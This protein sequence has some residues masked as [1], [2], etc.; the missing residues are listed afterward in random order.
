MSTEMK[1][2]LAS[3]LTDDEAGVGQTSVYTDV[4]A[5][6]TYRKKVDFWVLPL[7]CLVMQLHNFCYMRLTH[8]RCTFLIAWTGYVVTCSTVMLYLQN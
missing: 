7:L 8:F 4:E 1:Q 3:K 5:D 2:T 6:R